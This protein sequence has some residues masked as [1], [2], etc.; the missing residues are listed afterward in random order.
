MSQ[1]T[2]TADTD[3]QSDSSTEYT[4]THLAPDMTLPGTFFGLLVGGGIATAYPEQA[5]TALTVGISV[6]WMVGFAA[7]LAA[8]SW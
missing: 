5:K 3:A 8:E 7:T 4:P 2:P 1:E 6:G